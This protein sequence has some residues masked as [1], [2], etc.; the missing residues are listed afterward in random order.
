M[1]EWE[2]EGKKRQRVAN[3]IWFSLKKK[4]AR[5]KVVMNDNHKF[6]L[7]MRTTKIAIVVIFV[8][9]LLMWHLCF[10]LSFPNDAESSYNTKMSKN[11]NTNVK[12]LRRKQVFK[13]FEEIKWKSVCHFLCSLYKF[14]DA[15]NAWVCVTFFGS[16]WSERYWISYGSFFANE[17]LF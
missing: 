16:T 17:I 14:H 12:I 11:N 8:V 7:T 5:K 15:Y 3:L 4:I 10:S 1:S 9:V 2:W 6:P 13:F